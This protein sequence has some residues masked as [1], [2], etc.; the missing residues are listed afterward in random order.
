MFSQ[1]FV[2]EEEGIDV[3]ECIML[4]FSNFYLILL[5][6]YNLKKKKKS[7]PHQFMTNRCCKLTCKL[8]DLM[9]LTSKLLVQ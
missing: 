3:V 9:H 6:V 4:D 5:S 1:E 7:Y 2:I 8:Y